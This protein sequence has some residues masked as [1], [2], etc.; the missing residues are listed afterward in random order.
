MKRYIVLVFL[1]Y[2]FILLGIAFRNRGL[3]VL[4]IPL[5]VYLGFGIL[6]IP[7]GL[8]LEI[9]RIV[10]PKR[11][12]SNQPITIELSI[13][14]CGSHFE[15]IYIADMLPSKLTVIEG[16][17]SVL[18]EMA[19][20]E[21]TNLQYKI[22]GKRG[23][24][25]FNQVKVIK[26]DRLGLFHY[27]KNYPTPGQISILPSA[28]TTR[29][30]FIQP[31]QTR[32]YAGVVPSRQGGTGVEF[33]GL[34]RYQIGDPLHQINWKASA[35]FDDKLFTNLYK[36]ERAADVRI[37]LDARSKSDVKTNSDSLFEYS[38]QAATSIINRLIIDGNRVS[39]LIYGK[40]LE[41]TH[42]NSG[43]IQY[44]RILKALAGAETGNS[45][46]F[47]KFD[48]LPSRFMP[49]HSQ[50]ILISPL[51][52]TDTNSLIGLRA[53][54]YQLLI[55]SPDPIRF[56]ISTHER[57]FEKHIGIRVANLERKL[58][59]TQLQRAGIRVISWDIRTSFDQVLLPWRFNRRPYPL[60][61]VPR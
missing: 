59:I 2:L 7:D 27:T 18:L 34:R 40:Y 13:T 53:H 21:K 1:I 48:Y 17:S 12:T 14:N 9:E 6:G 25:H 32:L 35:R 5:L 37:I 16:E 10:Y 19:P 24:Y 3:L 42:P 23:I 52:P 47:E 38:I 46:V 39:L 45:L 20:G 58:M 55:I 26:S 54:G 57:Q 44:E 50:I 49:I 33:F 56:Q 8:Q 28:N 31:W 30:I 41:I 60:K 51:Q 29:Q 36:Q 4:S 22:I 43:K 15:N 61:A 11:I